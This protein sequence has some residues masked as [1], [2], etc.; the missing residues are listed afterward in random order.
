MLAFYASAKA[1]GNPIGNFTSREASNF[2]QPDR[3]SVGF[4]ACVQACPPGSGPVDDP[5][6]CRIDAR[7]ADKA[8]LGACLEDFQACPPAASPSGA[9]LN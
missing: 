1:S 2:C 8:C 4:K 7:S 6:Q 3:L 9:F 5:K